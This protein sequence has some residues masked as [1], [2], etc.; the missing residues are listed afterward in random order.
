MSTPEQRTVTLYALVPF[1]DSR[2]SYAKGQEFTMLH[3]TDSQQAEVQSL[4]TYGVATK[5]PPGNEPQVITDTADVGKAK[6][7]S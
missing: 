1:K 4:L 2:G 6:K 5:T 7:R 3:N